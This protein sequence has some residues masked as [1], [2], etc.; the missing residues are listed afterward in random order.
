VQSE[1]ESVSSEPISD[2][3]PVKPKPKKPEPNVVSMKD[4]LGR[5][6]SEAT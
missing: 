2:D 6:N 4:L 1:L 3:L 5:G